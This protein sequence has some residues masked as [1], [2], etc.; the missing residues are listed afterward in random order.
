MNPA[1]YNPSIADSPTIDYNFPATMNP[2]IIDSHGT[3]LNGLLYLAAGP[4]PHPTAILLHGFPGVER[5]LDVAQATRRAGWNVLYFHYRGAWG[6]A[7]VY[8]QR[9]T[10]EDTLAALNFL[11]ATG[12]TQYRVD[13]DRI[14]LIGHSMGGAC[15]MAAAIED[16]SVQYVAAL[17]GVNWDSLV[18]LA[19]HNP[20]ACTAL[21]AALDEK[22][23]PLVGFSGRTFLDEVISNQERYNVKPNVETLAGRQILLA[24]AARDEATPLEMH[25]LP[26]LRTLQAAGA[27]RLTHYIFDDDHYFS[28]HRIA[29]TQ[30]VVGW[31]AGLS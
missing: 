8:S 25:Y 29:L 28:H 10:V 7:G 3:K 30:L 16:S 5:N 15:A 2:L 19:R 1:P 23:A 24:G 21:A 20:A 17:A 26:M 12:T 4:G 27:A 14:A 18:D 22:S 13:P 11:R 6:S 31:L 9:H